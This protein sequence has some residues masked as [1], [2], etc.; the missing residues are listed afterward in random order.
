MVGAVS[1]G[2]GGFLFV[3]I[4]TREFPAGIAGSLF[5][6]TAVFLLVVA[7]A[8][9]GCDMGLVHFVATLHARHSLPGIQG[10][11]RVGLLPPLLVS[12]AASLLGLTFAK[13]LGRL[14]SAEATPSWSSTMVTVLAVFVPLA[15]ASDLLLAMTRGMGTMRPTV[16]VD[17][18]TRALAQ[19][20]LALTV[21]AL[22]G[23]ALGL[24]LAWAGPYL[25]AALL[26]LYLTSRIFRSGATQARR[27]PA[28]SNELRRAYWTF[29]APRAA[30]R[31]LQVAL[32]RA[33]VVII[34]VLAS[35]VDAAVYT[36][37]TRFVVLGQLVAQAAQQTLQP[38]ISSSLALG[39]RDTADRLFKVSTSWLVLLTWPIYLVLAIYPSVY[40]G[41]FGP[42]YVEAGDSVVIILALTLLLANALGAVDTVLVMAGR[43]G[44]SLVI[45]AIALAVNL[46][47]NIA[48]IPSL[49]LLGAAI[50]WSV[51]IV[52]RNVAA[53]VQL[54]RREGLAP[55]SSGLAY[56]VTASSVGFGLVAMLCRVVLGES[57]VAL[58]AVL[59]IGGCVFMIF[60]RRAPGSLELRAFRRRPGS[61][62]P[63]VP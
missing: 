16:L 58:A 28:A 39:K 60:L 10:I 63:E 6:L 41:L 51:A 9:L 36:V 4:T 25:G 46:A 62:R 27:G 45:T 29:T 56:A 32:L 24:T 38:Q 49:G 47:L 2:L 52:V 57:L 43:S 11:L 5:A 50:A 40:L 31:I 34:A 15:V 26:A 13:E 59:V 30:A 8:E 42:R 7:V 55:W 21:I 33:D 1:A 22:G 35:P 54:T 14:L 3:L 61:Q 18:V 23:G 12:F 17:R 19:P 37:A 53:L 20:L 48:L 44:V